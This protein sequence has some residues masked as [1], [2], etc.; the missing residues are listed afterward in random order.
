M[1][2]ARRHDHR[3]ARLL[4]AQTP[5]RERPCVPLPGRRQDQCDTAPVRRVW[6]PRLLMRTVRRLTGRDRIWNDNKES[7]KSAFWGRESLFGYALTQQH[8][9]RREW[10]RTFASRSVVRL[11]SQEQVSGNSLFSPKEDTLN[12]LVLFCFSRSKTCCIS[13]VPDGVRKFLRVMFVCGY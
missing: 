10:P 13:Q 6:F 11:R 8:R 9:R 2:D 12:L 5:A 3:P 7:L 4:G 1:D